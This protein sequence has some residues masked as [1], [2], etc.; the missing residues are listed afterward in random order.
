MTTIP[1]VPVF[2]RVACKFLIAWG[3]ALVFSALAHADLAQ[4]PAAGASSGFPERAPGEKSPLELK[5]IVVD[6]AG[7]YPCADSPEEWLVVEKGRVEVEFPMIQKDEADFRAVA[8]YL[9]MGHQTQFTADEQLLLHCFYRKMQSVWLKPEG[10]RYRVVME[11]EAAKLAGSTGPVTYID[12]HGQIMTVEQ[13][14]AAP[15][16]S[17][18]LQEMTA[19]QPAAGVTP[20]AWPKLEG[21]PVRYR[22]S[23]HYGEMHACSPM[24]PVSSGYGYDALKQGDPE[25]VKEIRRL[26]GMGQKPLTARGKKEVMAE[27]EKMKAMRVEKLATG[28]YF[29]L[30]VAQR[31]AGTAARIEGIIDAQGRVKELRRASVADICPK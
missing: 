19:E 3:A 26:L 9:G 17:R 22:L 15:S 30:T 14:S 7:L 27:Y 18:P 16:V 4:K 6:R 2:R 13:S 8:N 5:F 20:E 12:R 25:A 1:F 24:N 29:D 28:N 11:G 23:R 31:K 10:E 21:I